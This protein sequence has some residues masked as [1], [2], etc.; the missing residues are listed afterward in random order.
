MANFIE[1]LTKQINHDYVFGVTENGALGYKTTLN[2]FVDFNFKIPS[3]RRNETIALEDFAKCLNADTPL[4]MRLLFYLRDVRGG[5]GERKTF[6]VIA[7]N[8]FE[9]LENKNLLKLFPEYGRWDDLIYLFFNIKN[10]KVKAMIIEILY[11]QLWKDYVD[12][13]AGKPISLLAKWLP[14]ISSKSS[15][16]YALALYIPLGFKS[17]GHYRKTLSALRKKIDIVE[18]KM[19]AREWEHVDYSA[20]PSKA[21]IIYNSAFLRHDESRRR[22]FLEKVNKG[23]AKINSKVAFPHDIVHKYTEHGGFWG[24]DVK[25]YDMGLEMLW[26]SLPKFDGGENVLVVADTSGS[27]YRGYNR[28]KPCEIC[29]SLAIYFAERAKGCFNNKAILFSQRPEF[30][31]FGNCKSLR[32]KMEVLLGYNDISNTDIAKTFR[33]ILNAAEKAKLKQEDLP[34]TI[35]VI[36][37]MEFDANAKFD[38]RLFEGLVKEFQAK[39]YEMPKLVFWNV[40]SSTN[41][42]PITESK[43]GVTLVSGYSTN[44]VNMVLSDKL[45]AFEVLKEQLMNKRYDAVE[46]AYQ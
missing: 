36:S 46:K 45:D 33:L 37:D 5:L 13:Q 24:L 43:N 27:M 19:T 30:I 7:K 34:K 38:K 23:E 11:A 16:K 26:K 2:P 17:E 9:H 40:E 4:A 21:N 12:S 3:Y 44:I 10:K 25:D 6:R 41:T 29:F 32:D 15:R 1:A 35:L 22:N 31:D 20:V 18:R 8:L 39:G 42:I 28:I 14:T